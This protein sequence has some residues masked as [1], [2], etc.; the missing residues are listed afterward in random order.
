MKRFNDLDVRIQMVIIVL[1]LIALFIFAHYQHRNEPY[2][3]ETRYV[4]IIK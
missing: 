3:M 1:P 2:W 4:K